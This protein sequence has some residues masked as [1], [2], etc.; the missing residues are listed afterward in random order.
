[1]MYDLL[2]VMNVGISKKK[3]GDVIAKA[4]LCI[5]NTPMGLM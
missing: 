3:C 1:M 2:S 4:A 5:T